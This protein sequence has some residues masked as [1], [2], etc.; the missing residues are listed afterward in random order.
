MLQLTEHF[1]IIELR[2][3]GENKDEAC[4]LCGGIY[5]YEPRLLDA[6]EAYRVLLGLPVV[7]TSGNRCFWKTQQMNYPNKPTFNWNDGP[8]NMSQHQTGCAIDCRSG[9]LGAKTLYKAALEI[10]AFEQ[11]GIGVYTGQ[12]G[13]DR[14]HLDVRTKGRA[15][16]GYVGETKTHILEALECS[17][18]DR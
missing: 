15:R 12:K 7:V 11:G 14:M 2:C 5:I 18:E 9:G 13:D 10:P 8:L 3:R 4:P 17:K 1:Q 6:A 16:W